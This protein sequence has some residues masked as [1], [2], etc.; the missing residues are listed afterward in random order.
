MFYIFN[1][2]G[3]IVGNP[4]GY[5][6]IRQAIK[7]QNMKGSRAYNAIWEAFDAR[8]KRDPKW[9]RI[10]SVNEGKGGK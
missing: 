6:D 8:V 2:D 4:R 1:C 10:S 5:R 9:T 3:N 7:Q